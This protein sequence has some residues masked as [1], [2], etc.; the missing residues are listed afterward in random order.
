MSPRP[1]AKR[2]C[3]EHGLYGGTCRAGR[4]E[5]EEEEVRGSTVV[6]Q[7]EEGGESAAVPP[8]IVGV[9]PDGQEV[10]ARLHA[11]RQDKGG[12][13]YRIGIQLWQ[14]AANGDAQAAEHRAWVS[15]SQARPIPGVS[16][17]TAPGTQAPHSSMSSAAPPATT[18]SAGSRHSPHSTSPAQLRASNATPPD[19]SSPN[20]HPPPDCIDRSTRHCEG[21][22]PLIL[23]VYYSRDP[24]HMVISL[25]GAQD[26]LGAP[27][28]ALNS[29]VVPIHRPRR[30]P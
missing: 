3:L 19:P 24:R 23:S 6:D 28:T 22:F 17:P 4:R 12:W 18:P 5:E 7:G 30:T 10:R 2:L 21:M 27:P 15:T 13:R 1:I 14:D 11:R 8:P 29:P 20:S 9:L 26:T 25:Y 16:Y